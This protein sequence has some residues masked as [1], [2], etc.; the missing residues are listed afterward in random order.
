M[1]KTLFALLLLTSTTV[2]ASPGMRDTV[3][4]AF[5]NYPY[6][7][8]FKTCMKDSNG[9]TLDTAVCFDNEH[10]AWDKRLNKVYK[11]LLANERNLAAWKDAQ[12]KWI[13]FRDA[14][15]K[16]VQSPGSASVVDASNCML[17]MTIE[18]TLQL[19]DARWPLN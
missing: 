9:V 1:N 3:N 2:V 11:N 14:Q 6:S 10:Q 15:C 7:A 17:N 16:V 4:P 13:A 18:R 12:R 19:E 8:T 5:Y